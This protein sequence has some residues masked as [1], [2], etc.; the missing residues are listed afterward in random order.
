MD[1]VIQL[2]VLETFFE[3]VYLLHKQS[4]NLKTSEEN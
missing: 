4:K 1:A 2:C 3:F